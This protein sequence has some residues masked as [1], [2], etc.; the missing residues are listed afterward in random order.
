M[1]D[2]SDR[3]APLTAEQEAERRKAVLAERHK[4]RDRR[5]WITGLSVLGAAA[6]VSGGAVVAWNSQAHA[7]L[8]ASGIEQWRD[9]RD[10]A[11][12]MLSARVLAAIDAE[13]RARDVLPAART[14]GEATGVYGEAERAAFVEEGLPA[15]DAIA[16]GAILDE[17]DRDR[18]AA[19]EAWLDG[20][21]FDTD[22]CVAA[23]REQRAPVGPATAERADALARQWRSLG[24]ASDVDDDR[25]VEFEESLDRVRETAAAVAESR[26]E[27]AAL[28]S[29]L[30]AAP[31]DAFDGLDE[32]DSQLAEQAAVEAAD[33]SGIFELVQL[34]ADRASAT[35]EVEALA[36]AAAE[37]EAATAPTPPAIVRPTPGRPGRPGQPPAA[38]VQPSPP[39]PAPAPEPA[40]TIP[41]PPTEPAPEPQPEPE[42]EPEQPP[43]DPPV[44]PEPP[45]DPGP[46][47]DPPFVP[48]PPPGEGG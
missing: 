44:N 43:V 1:D 45:V 39:V 37:E 25:V 42:P 21:V 5:R 35:R 16:R 4:Q 46:V 47:P 48:A 17:A 22:A 40:P 11:E 29:S 8:A 41:E 3:R 31:V 38:P 9:E 24:D 18:A 28:R 32:I 10:A 13:D 33:A 14:I 7:E 20:G 2:E 26:T 34:L 23:A 27:L 36:A 15:L 6:I 19:A 12:C 30:D